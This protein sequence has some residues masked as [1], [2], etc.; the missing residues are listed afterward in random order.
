MGRAFACGVYVM[1]DDDTFHCCDEVRGTVKSAQTTR[2]REHG[3][4][5]GDGRQ[6][7]RYDSVCSSSSVRS[8]SQPFRLYAAQK[9]LYKDIHRLSTHKEKSLTVSHFISFTENFTVFLLQYFLF[10]NLYTLKLFQDRV[11]ESFLR[12]KDIL[13]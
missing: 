11:I 3:S 8:I 7:T 4:E 12:Q 1:S 13:E 6:C 5:A 9:V 2:Q 10:P